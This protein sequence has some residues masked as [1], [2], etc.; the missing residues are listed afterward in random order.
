MTNLSAAARGSDLPR[1][2]P[3]GELPNFDDLDLDRQ[4]E[5]AIGSLAHAGVAG[6]S[7][8]APAAPASDPKPG[9]ASGKPASAVPPLTSPE[10]VVGLV[11]GE[12]ARFYQSQCKEA[13]K[14]NEK[15]LEEN[16][17]VHEDYLRVT[18]TNSELNDRLQNLTKELTEAKRELEARPRL[19]PVML[20][21]LT[22]EAIERDWTAFQ[23]EMQAA[24]PKY[25]AWK[26]QQSKEPTAPSSSQSPR[27]N[28]NGSASP[29]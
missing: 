19:D 7:A 25:F 3:K 26:A 8:S 29:K 11:G 2:V 18:R 21:Q 14:D 20:G 16:Q 27:P 1:G 24:H 4:L 12:T 13:L 15:L 22:Q 17:K 28:G 6:A 5:K 10:E 23:Q 9:I